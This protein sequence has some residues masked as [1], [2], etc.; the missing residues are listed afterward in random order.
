V[1]ATTGAAATT[2]ATTAATTVATAAAATKPWLRYPL[3]KALP[4]W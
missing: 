1:T 2:V 4:L 3:L